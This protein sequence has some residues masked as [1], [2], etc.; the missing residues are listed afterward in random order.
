[1]VP[2]WQNVYSDK[3]VILIHIVVHFFRIGLRQAVGFVKGCIKQMGKY[4]KV[5][6]YTQASRR[7]KKLNLKIDDHRINKCDWK[8]IEIA[9]DSTRVSIYNNNGG[10]SK[11]NIRERKYNGYRKLYVVLNTNDKKAIS[12]LVVL[13]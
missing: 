8:S 5:I 1:M 10:H 4:F 6:S 12:I 7:F 13:L 11:L 2:K 9:I 3:V